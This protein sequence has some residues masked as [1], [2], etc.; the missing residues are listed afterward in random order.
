MTS[1]QPSA[2]TADD[3]ATLQRGVDSV[4]L[5]VQ[6]ARVAEIER[7][8]HGWL[9]Y[10]A[11]AGELLAGTL[12]PEMTLALVAQLVAPR[13]G[14]W[15]AV[16][17]VD[18]SGR[19]ERATVWHSDEERMEDLRALPRLR[20][21]PRPPSHP[22][23]HPLAAARRRAHGRVARPPPATSRRPVATSSR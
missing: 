8:R 10:L 21:C 16:Y 14:P 22:R 2:F 12:E 9:G 15:C 18:E 20:T 17:L 23:R 6:S 4:A 1:G 13:L 3:G 19:S 5:A 11:E 7:R